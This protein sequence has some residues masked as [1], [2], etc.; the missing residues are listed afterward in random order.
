MNKIIFI[1]VLISLPFNL[2]LSQQ[3]D[4][5]TVVTE[6]VLDNLLDDTDEESENSELFDLLEDLIQNPIDINTAD[7]N[8]LQRLP[9]IDP[10]KANV[11]IEHRNK[12]GLFYSINELFSIRDL[13]TK[14][15][16]SIL[17]FVT[18]SSL[19][20]ESQSINDNNINTSSFLDRSKLFIRSRIMND[21]QT[22]NAF[23]NGRYEGSKLKSYNRM[24]YNYSNNF[25][26]GFL[27][28]KDPGEKSFTDF[29]S[30]HLQAKEIGIIKSFIVGDYVLE[31]GQGLALWS[32]FG[33][34]KGADAIYPVKK[35]SRYLRPYTS[36]LEYRF[37]RGA[38]TRINLGNFDIT[39][40]YSYNTFDATI[41]S[42]TGE[43][44]SFGQTGYHRTA[45]E[46]NRKGA[47]NSR[48]I[49]G[50]LDYSFLSNQKVGLI[51][52]NTSFD[53]KLLAKSLYDVEGDNFNY[54]SYYYD[55]NF[56]KINLFGEFSY[57]GTS[58][59]SIN[60]LQFSISNEFVYTTAIRSYP[61]NYKNL[62]GFGFSERTGKINN[63]I[64]IYSG[65]KWKTNIGVINLYYD[66]FKFPYKTSENSLSSEGNELLFNL[67]SRPFVKVETRLR[68]K[69]ENKEV[70]EIINS[71]QN[72]VRRL[73]QIIR[74]EFLY[75]ISSYLRLKW[76]FEYNHFLIREASIK[77]TGFLMF[78][79]VRYLLQRNLSFYGR[80]IFFH[81]DSFNS[82][83]YEFENDL[84]GVMP[85]LAMFGRG[86]RWYLILKY[87]PVSELTISAKYAETFKPREKFLSSGD[88]QINNNVD[89][90]LSLQI[91][92]K[93]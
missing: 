71:N 70:S 53:R 91:D 77:E 17:P 87:R 62:Y 81:T 61:R 86:L 92:F 37:F 67:T 9:G 56:S 10:F 22:R 6:D 7:I 79:D 4:S 8:E 52:Y 51:V 29:A 11:L 2:L 34:S 43:I 64:G 46:L 19:N 85:N 45:N 66:I 32:P 12:Y 54:V 49:G 68:Y 24:L 31:Y 20:Q 55:F 21:L 80:I 89:N 47:V 69:F 35:K 57:D 14:S 65:L 39:T 50:V 59:A 83:V 72:I 5:S 60:G 13:D 48:V 33:F 15:I 76:R 1:T 30:F 28:E 23:L 18:V 88:N 84:F 44:T 40:F 75:D 38:S 78:Q 74:T 82:A 42:I 93:F 63:E 73:K 16:Q 90:R 36:S 41:D 3:V 26:L 25:Q 27:T 58:V